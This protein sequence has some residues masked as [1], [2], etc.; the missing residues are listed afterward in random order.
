MLVGKGKGR[1]RREVPYAEL[2][3]GISL[4][5]VA[6]LIA[7]RLREWFRVLLLGVGLALDV[8]RLGYWE[9]VELC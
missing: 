2:R 1:E 7:E 9:L 4:P 3:L 6:V 8:V 5:R